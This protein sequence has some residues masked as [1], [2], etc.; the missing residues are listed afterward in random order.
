M[1]TFKQW[2]QEDESH[3]KISWKQSVSDGTR[4]IDKEDLS[5]DYP[6]H[7]SNM[8]KAYPFK[9]LSKGKKNKKTKIKF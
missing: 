7:L 4:E 8:G 9:L 2:L 1:R 3:K 5:D 6:D